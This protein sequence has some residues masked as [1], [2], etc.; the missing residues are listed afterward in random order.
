MFNFLKVINRN[1]VSFFTLDT[2]KTIFDDV[3]IT[4][5]VR[6]DMTIQ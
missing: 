2:I 1:T 3:I 4:S 5:A 6:K